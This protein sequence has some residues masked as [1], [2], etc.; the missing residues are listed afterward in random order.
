MPLLQKR[1]E[2]S[3]GPIIGEEDVAYGLYSPDVFDPVTGRL[4]PEAVK[5][6]DLRGP[7]GGHENTCGQSTG[8]SVCRVAHSS[9]QDEL[10]R[11]LAQIVARRPDRAIEGYATAN[12]HHI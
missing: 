6:G 1:C 12:V 8:V 10:R 5:I 7:P 3:P 11:V 9:S 2:D 4:T